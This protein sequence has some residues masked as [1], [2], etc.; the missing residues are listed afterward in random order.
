METKN[1]LTKV[2]KIITLIVNILENKVNNYDDDSNTKF[3][4][5][6]IGGKENMVSTVSKLTNLLIKIIPLE[7]K[8]NDKEEVGKNLSNDDMKIVLNYIKKREKS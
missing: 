5:F 3:I 7:E 8:F 1:D 2:R 6:I 4:K